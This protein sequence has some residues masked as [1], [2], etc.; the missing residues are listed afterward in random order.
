MRVRGLFACVR[1]CVSEMCENEAREDERDDL[2]VHLPIQ[3]WSV[4]R[5]GNRR[6]ASTRGGG[7]DT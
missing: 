1:V 2:V 7:M 6:D 4:M 3:M 5:D